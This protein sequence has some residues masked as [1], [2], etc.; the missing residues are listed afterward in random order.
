MNK[1]KSN[2][3]Q[4][5][6]IKILEGLE[7]VRKR[8]AMYIGDNTIR[9][10][11]HLVFEV[12]DN[13]I[14]EALA[15]FCAKID[16]IIHIDNSITISD[17]GRGIPV[18][19]H[20]DTNTSAAEVV[21]TTLHAGGKF[22]QDAYKV[23]G[24]LHGVG[25]SVVNALSSAFYLEI[26]RDGKVYSQSYV[27]GV[28]VASLKEMGEATGTGT[29]I[30]FKADGEI[31]P[32]TKFNFEILSERL[33]ELSFLNKGVRILI[34]DERSDKE[35]DFHYEGGIVSFI[36]YLNRNKKTLFAPPIFIEDDQARIAM[37][38]AMAYNDGYKEDVFSFAN[39]IHTREGGTHLAGFRS[40]LTRTINSYAI[41][42]GLIKKEASISGDDVRE[43]LTAVLSVK[44]PEPQF[45]GQT[46][47]KLGNAEVQGMVASV[48][49][50]KL[51]Q[52]L[53]EN[54]KEARFIVSKATMAAQARE[55]AKRARDLTRRKSVLESS[56]LPGKLA[57]C[58][59]KDPALCELYLVEGDSA[60]GS[61]KQGRDRKY[62]AILPL[63]GKI[64]NVEKARFEKMLASEEIRKL[65]TAIGSGIGMDDFNISKIRYNKIILM[66]DADVDGSHIRTL[67]LT[68]FFRHMEEI[69][70]RGYLY[71][72][73]PPLYKVSKG[74][75]SRYIT[76]DKELE[77]HLL[78]IGLKGKELAISGSE[79]TFS[80]Q[81]LINLVA[82]MIDYGKLL[83]NLIRRGYPKE[84]VELM[85]DENIMDKEYFLE[86]GK[87]EK[88]SEGFKETK[89]KVNIVDDQEHGGMAL[90]WYDTR[91]GVSRTINW[92]LVLSAEYQLLH[93][94]RRQIEKYDNPP[95]ILR[96]KDSEASLNNRV[97]LV[98]HVMKTSNNGISIQR[99]KGLG[100]M[101]ADQLWETT[102]DPDRRTL[103]QVRINDA[104]AAEEIFTVLMGDQVEPRRDFIQEHALDVRNLD[105]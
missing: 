52:F 14:D 45:E 44:I 36:E 99:Y 57:D 62:Q 54:P 24:G 48:I 69:I 93:A 32:N 53:E 78:E 59:E 46:K 31:F 38:L 72:A 34:K 33:R 81:T 39:N 98:E 6:S 66:T 37:E 27:K 16:V 1:D 26:R 9:G 85:L 12:V 94:I 60:G 64:L 15:G 10:L 23:S 103:Q 86:R 17:D 55:A 20:P 83:N 51:T 2:N 40:A 13:S 70:H 102:M 82:K 74:K 71:I 7:A 63:K 88:I 80:E 89:F 76:D 41:S 43:G 49:N 4:A 67:L 68:L 21:M 91:S 77:S 105:I 5:D 22:D 19:I 50:K 30:T 101:N 42:N 18:D 96:S 65:V 47:T 79:E 61:A 29:K 84:V 56:L 104:V 75:N 8:P 28:P 87:L 97:E 100:E 35:H 90:E 11:S 73:K 25:V 95:F 92:D 58:Q 3:Y